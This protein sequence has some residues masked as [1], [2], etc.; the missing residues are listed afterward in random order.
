MKIKKDGIKNLKEETEIAELMDEVEDLTG[1]IPLLLESCIVG[2]EFDLGAEAMSSIWNQATSF[3]SERKDE[4]HQYRWI[5]YFTFLEFKT[6]LTSI[7]YCDYVVA[8]IIGKRTPPGMAPNLIDHRYFYEDNGTGKYACGLARDAVAS[9]LRCHGMYQLGDLGI[10][11]SL[12]S[13]T[14]A[15]PARLPVSR[16]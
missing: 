8:C 9:Q 2:G 12:A 3:I 4:N 7:R 11:R 5:R 13:S 10:L 16:T 15:S 6:S 1:C 14:P